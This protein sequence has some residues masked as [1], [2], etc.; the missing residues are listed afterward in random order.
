[1][2]I[3]KRISYQTYILYTVYFMFFSYCSLVR[4]QIYIDFG[5]EPENAL[6]TDDTVVKRKLIPAFIEL[7]CC[8]EHMTINR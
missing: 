2:E 6:M 3:N 4:Q 5:Y 1:M 8:Y 7:S